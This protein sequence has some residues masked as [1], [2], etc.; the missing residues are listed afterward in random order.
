MLSEILSI[1]LSSFIDMSSPVESKVV[2]IELNLML[3]FFVAL[4]SVSISLIESNPKETN[5]GFL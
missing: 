2:K 4:D 3:F 5:I 1:N